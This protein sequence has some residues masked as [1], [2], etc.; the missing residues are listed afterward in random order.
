ML[1]CVIALLRQQ[2]LHNCTT[3]QLI[4]VLQLSECEFSSQLLPIFPRQC[5]L[6]SS[7]NMG[8]VVGTEEVHILEGIAVHN[9]CDIESPDTDFQADDYLP[10]SNLRVVSQRSRENL[11]VV[12]THPISSPFLERQIQ[13]ECSLKSDGFVLIRP[14]NS[15]CP[16]TENLSPEAC[17]CCIVFITRSFD[18]RDEIYTAVKNM[19]YESDASVIHVYLDDS[20]CLPGISSF[21]PSVRMIDVQEGGKALAAYGLLLAH[22]NVAASLFDTTASPS[23]RRACRTVPIINSC[24]SSPKASSSIKPPASPVSKTATTKAIP[25]SPTLNI[26]P[27]LSTRGA[28]TWLSFHRL[29]KLAAA[30]SNSGAFQEEFNNET[31]YEHLGASRNQIDCSG[32]DLTVIYIYY[33]FFLRK[34]LIHYVYDSR[35]SWISAKMMVQTAIVSLL[36]VPAKRTSSR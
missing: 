24:T 13:I 35:Y 32:Q 19:F 15:S 16:T 2:R 17:C 21:S 10:F 22:I 33:L 18:D 20:P 12:S 27:S 25:K 6:L 30:K 26:F 9:V 14:P 1:I 36:A 5:F 11:Y 8:N 3:A 28:S 34:L 4:N 31:E 23:A 29:K 7:S